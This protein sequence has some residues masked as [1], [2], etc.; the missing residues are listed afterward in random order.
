MAIVYVP[1]P[2]QIAPRECSAGRLIERLDIDVV[3]PPD[4]GVQA[5]LRGIAARH[6]IPFFDPTGAMRDYDRAADAAPLSLRSDCH[7]SARGHQFIALWFANFVEDL[8]S[9]RR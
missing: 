3:L 1:N 4:S 8:A 2:Y 6:D 7:W 5:W 9:T